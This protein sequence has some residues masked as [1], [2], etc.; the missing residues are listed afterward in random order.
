MEII[1]FHPSYSYE[2]FI[3]GIKPRLSSE[4]EAMDLLDNKEYS[5]IWLINVSKIQIKDLFSLLM[6]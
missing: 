3:E 5:K 6:R 1:Q 4:G 2:D